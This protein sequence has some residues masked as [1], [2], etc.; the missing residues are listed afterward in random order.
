MAGMPRGEARTVPDPDGDLYDEMCLGQRA[1]NDAR[2]AELCRR[3][4]A[5]KI[6]ETAETTGKVQKAA[7]LGSAMFAVL[8]GA[9][10]DLKAAEAIRKFG[11]KLGPALSLTAATAGYRADRQR[12]VPK[13]EALI[14]N[15][16]GFVLGQTLGK[17]GAV[18][19]GAAA[20]PFARRNPAI[21]PA[22]AGVGEYVGGWDGENIAK[23]LAAG[24]SGL[25]STARDVGGTTLRGVAAMNEP[26]PHVGRGRLGADPHG[27]W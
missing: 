25:K 4:T 20:L 18:S 9:D 22:A 3:S 2:E 21:V 17:L 24:W 26:A 15:G 5:R 12:G 14:R 1:F 23:D 10:D 6:K 11:G 27:R 19:F 8:S 16:G 7:E 13:D